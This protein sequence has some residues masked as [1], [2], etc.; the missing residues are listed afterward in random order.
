MWLPR[1]FECIKIEVLASLGE[2]KDGSNVLLIPLLPP[3][4]IKVQ[5][6]TNKTR[7]IERGVW[8]ERE[9]GS[10]GGESLFVFALLF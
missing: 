5:P 10:E 6:I 8:K 1:S 9:G 4:F 3:A 7:T 2:E